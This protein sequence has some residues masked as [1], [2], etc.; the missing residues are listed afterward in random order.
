MN[1]KSNE[2]HINFTN[3]SRKHYD[4]DFRKQ[5][6]EVCKSG[7][8]ASVAEC[9]RNYG[10]NENTL[11]NWLHKSKNALFTNID[12]EYV[13]YCLKTGRISSWF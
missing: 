10:I 13:D 8:Y 5:V 12:P 1:Q 11:H 4:A 2:N 3:S 7:T 6:I 9:A